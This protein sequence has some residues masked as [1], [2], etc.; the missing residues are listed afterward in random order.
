MAYEQLA[1]VGKGGRSGKWSAFLRSRTRLMPQEFGANLQ[2][3][4]L[5]LNSR[6]KAS[7]VEDHFT[8]LRGITDWYIS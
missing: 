7:G 1:D 3:R 5:E 8:A 6:Q 2:H 4:R